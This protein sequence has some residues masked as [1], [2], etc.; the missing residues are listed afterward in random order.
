MTDLINDGTLVTELLDDRL[1]QRPE[2]IGATPGTRS[3]YIRYYDANDRWIVDV[4]RYLLSDGSL[5]GSGLADPKRMRVGGEV[6][7]ADPAMKEAESNK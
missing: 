4:H 6:W 5:G 1:L 3:Q 2:A 7:I